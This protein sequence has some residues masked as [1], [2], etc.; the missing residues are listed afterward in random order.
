M[1]ID[2]ALWK[3]IGLLA[4]FGMFMAV[5]LYLIFARRGKYDAAARL[6]LDDEP[7]METDRIEDQGRPDH[8]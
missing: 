8:G 2:P 4:C 3:E 6:P 5:A 7:T 1:S